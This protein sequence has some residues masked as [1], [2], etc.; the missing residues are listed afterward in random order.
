MSNLHAHIE[1]IL[2]VSAKPMSIKK[3][4]DAVDASESDVT[5][6]IDEVMHERNVENSGVHIL[7]ND[8][9]VQL[10]T[11]PKCADRVAAFLEE[12]I[13][14]ELT[15]P[16]LEALTIVAYRGPITKPEIEAIR[17]VNCSL[18]LRNLL[19]RGLVTEADDAIKMQPVYTLSSDALRYFGVHTVDELPDYDTLHVNAKIE[20]LLASLA[21]T[22]SSEVV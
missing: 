17:G 22:P 3:L 1:A 20:Q 2:F 19:M 5:H 21:M 13:D 15:R 8:N 14:A 4:A 18:I 16:S 6:A 12:D 9:D 11:N 7:K 10:A